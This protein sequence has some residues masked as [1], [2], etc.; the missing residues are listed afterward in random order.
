MGEACRFWKHIAWAPILVLSFTLC[1][2]FFY[3][4]KGDH[5]GSHLVGLW[6]E[7]N[8]PMRVKCLQQCLTRIANHSDDDEGKTVSRYPVLLRET[9]MRIEGSA[10]EAHPAGIKAPRPL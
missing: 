9:S 7:F 10:L 4:Y 6:W 5:D 3:P 1:L 8:M 2:R